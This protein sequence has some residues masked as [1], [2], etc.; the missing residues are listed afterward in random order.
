VDERSD[1]LDV[2]RRDPKM[3]DDYD[4]QRLSATEAAGGSVEPPAADEVQTTNSHVDSKCEIAQSAGSRQRNDQR[5]THVVRPMM[6][7]GHENAFSAQVDAEGYQ[8]GAPPIR[9]TRKNTLYVTATPLEIARTFSGKRV[10]IFADIGPP[11][12]WQLREIVVAKITPIYD[13]D[14]PW[15]LLVDPRNLARNDAPSV[16]D[17]TAAEEAS[18]EDTSRALPKFE[19]HA[20]LETAAFRS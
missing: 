4:V 15:P 11:V 13:N 19:S 2:L 5:A 12:A 20:T 8:I 14:G 3:P 10:A 6:A 1:D 16:A 18:R 17:G 9:R 7:T